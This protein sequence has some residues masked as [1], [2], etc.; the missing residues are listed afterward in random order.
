MFCTTSHVD[1]TS[2]HIS[3]QDVTGHNCTCAS[4]DKSC[5]VCIEVRRYHHTSSI[6]QV[7][8]RD[9]NVGEHN[10]F[11]KACPHLSLHTTSHDVTFELL[12][13]F[14]CVCTPPVMFAQSPPVMA[15]SSGKFATTSHGDITSHA[16][17]W[18]LFQL[19]FFLPDL[20][21]AHSK[22]KSDRQVWCGGVPYWFTPDAVSAE[23]DAYGI[24]PYQVKL[25]TRGGMKDL[26]I[27]VSLACACVCDAAASD[28]LQQ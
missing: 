16:S 22:M 5:Q 1:I 4:H 7:V 3:K 6:I 14:T 8:N 9:T 26:C 13:R 24:R 17:M 21:M 25:I 28:C 15:T 10:S 27:S 19:Q 18:L 20:V 11:H 2:I 12:L 23:L